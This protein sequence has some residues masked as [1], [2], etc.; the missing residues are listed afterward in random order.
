MLDYK[1]YIQKKIFYICLF[2]NLLIIIFYLF[3]NKCLLLNFV[4]FFVL[5]IIWQLEKLIKVIENNLYDA[6]NRKILILSIF[7]LIMNLINLVFNILRYLFYD[8]IKIIREYFRNVLIEYFGIILDNRLDFYIDNII[9][10]ISWDVVWISM[11]FLWTIYFLSY[12]YSLFDWKKNE[13]LFYDEE[14]QSQLFW[15]HRT[16]LLC[17]IYC[18]CFCYWRFCVGCGMLYQVFFHKHLPSFFLIDFFVILGFLCAC[19]CVIYTIQFNV[20]YYNYILKRK[21][22]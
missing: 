4:F 5:I 20:A 11:G 9:A 10:Y 13:L 22:L 7:L 8:F 19:I 6:I 16:Q 15:T 14:L 3:E 18:F 2:L 17:D 21:C 12:Y 1:M